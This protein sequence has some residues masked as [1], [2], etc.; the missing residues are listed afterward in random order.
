MSQ[1]SWRKRKSERKK[2][3][4]SLVGR[5]GDIQPITRTQTPYNIKDPVKAQEVSDSQSFGVMASWQWF[6]EPRGMMNAI[7]HSLASPTKMATYRHENK[8]H[9]RTRGQVVALGVA[10]GEQNKGQT[11]EDHQDQHGEPDP[12]HDAGVEG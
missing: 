7:F 10:H 6:A 4:V 12:G 3:V 5:A 9:Q 8:A 11:G 2:P 1:M